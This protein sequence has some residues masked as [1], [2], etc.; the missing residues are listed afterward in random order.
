MPDEAQPTFF[1]QDQLCN[2]SCLYPFASQALFLFPLQGIYNVKGQPLHAA[3]HLKK[4]GNDCWL[5]AYDLTVV[6][7][8][9]CLGRGMLRFC[10]SQGGHSPANL[11]RMLAPTAC[12]I[13]KHHSLIF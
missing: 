3:S 5:T 9:T 2:T 8:W 4:C 6:Q 10:P 12:D 7:D 11:N 1:V 13:N